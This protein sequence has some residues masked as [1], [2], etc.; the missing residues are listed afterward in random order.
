M[1]LCVKR[2]PLF[3][4]Y[5]LPITASG[6]DLRT[7]ARITAR[8]R[9][10]P[11]AIWNLPC[12]GSCCALRIMFYRLLILSLLC[13]GLDVVVVFIRLLGEWCGVS[14]VWG[15]GRG[16]SSRSLEI[17]WRVASGEQRVSSF[18]WVSSTVYPRSVSRVR[19]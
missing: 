19:L 14:T 17:A 3:T 1:I 11:P 5:K 18:A 16:S 13:L 4:K 6:Q 7:P 10:G 15:G 2:H 8:A 9:F 12:S